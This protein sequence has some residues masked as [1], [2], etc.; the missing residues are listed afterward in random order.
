MEIFLILEKLNNDILK[1]KI[2]NMYFENKNIKI[3]Q[4]IDFYINNDTTNIIHDMI[5]RIIVDKYNHLNFITNKGHIVKT[6]N[7]IKLY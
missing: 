2:S 1:V 4:E 7:I 3:N 5:Q 6:N